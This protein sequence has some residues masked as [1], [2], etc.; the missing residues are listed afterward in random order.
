[1]NYFSNIFF[2]AIIEASKPTLSDI[3][4]LFS[5]SLIFNFFIFFL[6][7]EILNFFGNLILRNAINLYIFPVSK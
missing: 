3:N 7:N 4:F 5:K 2:F 1:M 6:I